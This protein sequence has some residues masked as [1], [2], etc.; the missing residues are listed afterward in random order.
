MNWGNFYFP[1]LVLTLLQTVSVHLAEPAVNSAIKN[2]REQKILYQRVERYL[3]RLETELTNTRNDQQD[4]VNDSILSIYRVNL[5]QRLKILRQLEGLYSFLFAI[6]PNQSL[7][8]DRKE[9]I[10]LQ[11]EEVDRNLV[12][13]PF[14]ESSRV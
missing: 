4:G 14:I 9:A 8:Q 10:R 2:R 3:E 11:R 6:G 13:L 1:V 5:N 7:V 12:R